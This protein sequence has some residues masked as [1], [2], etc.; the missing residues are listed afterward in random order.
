MLTSY[1]LIV[2]TVYQFIFIK[3]IIP[4]LINFLIIFFKSS[5]NLIEFLCN[6]PNLNRFQLSSDSLVFF[7]I[8]T[9]NFPPTIVY[10]FQ[11][12]QTQ[13]V[14]E[15]NSLIIFLN[16]NDIVNNKGLKFK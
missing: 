12:T 13:F 1:K 11:F 4:L 5:C 9:T 6:E 14:S 15:E 2:N 3:T 10:S 16:R 8:K 7:K